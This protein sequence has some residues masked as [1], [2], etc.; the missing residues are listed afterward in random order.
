[1]KIFIVPVNIYFWGFSIWVLLLGVLVTGID[2]DPSALSN[3]SFLLFLEVPTVFEG[4]FD[5]Y[6]FYCV[7]ILFCGDKRSVG[8][9]NQFLP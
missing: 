4:V 3:V 6:V 8:F 2:P 5:F 1:M 7:N 9:L